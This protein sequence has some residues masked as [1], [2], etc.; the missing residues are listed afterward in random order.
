M[1]SLTFIILFGQG[2]L[3]FH[4]GYFIRKLKKP[5][6]GLKGILKGGFFKVGIKGNF[7]GKITDGSFSR[8]E[9]LS[10]G[11]ERGVGIWPADKAQERCFSCTVKTDKT[12]MVF[13]S[14]AERGIG[15]EL[16]CSNTEGEISCFKHDRED[17]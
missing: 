2:E 15:Q 13:V 16:F 6:V 3:V 9:K 11:N 10:G 7:L 12:D 5:D 17:F 14:Y 8:F 1:I 4:A